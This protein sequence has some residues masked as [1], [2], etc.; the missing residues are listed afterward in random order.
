MGYLK[1]LWDELTSRPVKLS[2]EETVRFYQEFGFF[3]GESAGEVVAEYD[4]DFSDAG[5]PFK[6]WEDVLLLSLS[7]SR[8]WQGDPEADVC[9]GNEVYI[10]TLSEWGRISEGA[11]APSEISEEWGSDSGPVTVIFRLGSELHTIHPRYQDDYLDLD[12]LK[13]INALIL[14]SGRQFAYAS[15]VNFAVVLCLKPEERARISKVRDFPFAW[16]VA[17]KG[18]N[19]SSSG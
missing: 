13:S 4:R 15:D 2:R 9:S 14:P 19:S 5:E 18:G 1:R 7:K 16:L 6:R 8:V 11:F 12:V 10:E 17:N 3:A